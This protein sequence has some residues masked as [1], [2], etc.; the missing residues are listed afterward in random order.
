MKHLSRLDLNLFQIFDTIYDKGGVSAAARHLDLTQSAISHALARLRDMF[1]DPLFVR[2]GNRLVPTTAARAVAGPIRD[3]LRELVAAMESTAAFDPATTTREFRIGMRLAGENSRFPHLAARVLATAPGAMLTSAAFGRRDLLKAL[4]NGDLDCA[5]DVPLPAEE[6]LCR[7]PLGAEPL[8][9]VAW[10]GHPGVKVGMDL[11]RYIALHHVVAT[12]RPHGP[13]LEDVA[14][15]R[16][17]LR[18]RVAIRCQHAMTAWQIVAN[19]D[20][21]CT[22]P[23]TQAHMLQSIWP[24]QLFALPVPVEESGSFLYWHAAAQSDPGLAWLRQLIAAAMADRGHKS[25]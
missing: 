11:D 24:I 21:I 22:I 13:G 10:P 3:A 17:G 4:A 15:E 18:R 19:S 12:A 25:S 7:Q 1:G 6:R 16:L 20:L 23:D 2:Q 5:I 14:L 8:V 9:V